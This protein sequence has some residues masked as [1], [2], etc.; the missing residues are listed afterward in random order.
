MII[1]EMVADNGGGYVTERLK[2][3]GGWLVVNRKHWCGET[4]RPVFVS[5]PDHLW[6]INNEPN[7]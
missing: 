5:D 2:V 1:W 3:I 7:V 4:T 6:E